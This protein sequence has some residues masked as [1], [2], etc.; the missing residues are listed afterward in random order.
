M[1][2]YILSQDQWNHFLSNIQDTQNFDYEAQITIDNQ[3]STVKAKKIRFDDKIV[4]FA[5][6]SWVNIEFIDCHFES[7]VIIKIIEKWEHDNTK[8]SIKFVNCY[9][10]RILNNFLPP[11]DSNMYRMATKIIAQNSL[12]IGSIEIDGNGQLLDLVIEQ[13]ESNEDFSIAK[14]A[15]ESGQYIRMKNVTVDELDITYA[16][17]LDLKR[18]IL[19][20]SNI[21]KVID[22]TTTDSCSIPILNF[23]SLHQ[24]NLSDSI[25]K[26]IIINSNFGDVN[27]SKITVESL[28]FQKSGSKG[29]V[30]IENGCNIGHLAFGAV[31]INEIVI[32]EATIDHLILPIKLAKFNTLNVTGVSEHPL[33]INKLSL[34]NGT[35]QQ[36]ADKDKPTIVLEGFTVS[37]INFASF[38][39][40]SNV[41]IS[42]IEYQ[43]RITKSLVSVLS[44]EYFDLLKSHKI[45]IDQL[46]TQE[47]DFKLLNSDLG[48]I[49]FISC[50][51]S[52]MS[53]EIKASKISEIFLAGTDMPATLQGD[54]RDIQI[55]YAQLKK[56]YESRGDSVKSNEYLALELNA[57]YESLNQLTR[58]K[59]WAEF[60]DYATLF[61]NK[62]SNNFGTDW[63]RA[64]WL[65]MFVM[66]VVYIIHNISLGYG[67]IIY[68]PN[69]EQIDNFKE[70]LSLFPE[71][72]FPIHKADYIPEVVKLK[73]TY[74][75][76][77]WDFVGRILSAYFIYQFIFAFRKYGKK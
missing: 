23:E 60:R 29:K 17:Y 73:I 43:P 69:E 10:N 6:V 77:F 62:Y 47:S 37:S 5:L 15:V 46:E 51:F 52:E 41:Y 67:L 14:I 42:G 8:A 40:N 53:M 54:F 38:N 58:K 76:R 28:E 59:T 2:R 19:N 33:H 18:T 45:S 70:I 30:I 16:Q 56:V 50:N 7:D 48:K 65:L 22:F 61:T 26:E 75:S 72:L 39:N 20:K 11:N 12:H 4:V 66:S 32:S 44:S 3:T 9:I 68:K 13:D 34:I 1:N 63:W 64:L 35:F 49:N 36:G 71:F 25:F 57:H 31:S 24:L 21:S 55:G 74:A 27:I